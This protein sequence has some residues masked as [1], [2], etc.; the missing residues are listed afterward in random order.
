MSCDYWRKKYWRRLGESLKLYGDGP[1]TS[2][3]GLPSWV[4]NIVE[5][6]VE[7]VVKD[8]IENI[9]EDELEDVPIPES[10]RRT[11]QRT[12]TSNPFEYSLE[13]T[14]RRAKH[15]SRTQ[16]K[17]WTQDE[18]NSVA[19]KTRKLLRRIRLLGLPENASLVHGKEGLPRI[20]SQAGYAAVHDLLV[21]MGCNLD[22]VFDLVY[23]AAE[24]SKDL[25]SEERREIIC[26]IERIEGQVYK[27]S[28]ADISSIVK[29][30]QRIQ[31][32]SSEIFDLLMQVFQ[33]LSSKRRT[34]LE[35][36]NL[37]KKVLAGVTSFEQA[38]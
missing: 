29:D 7:D 18:R 9:L 27:G 36:R 19:K 3:G 24:N 28:E 2:N 32:I 8:I 23:D 10:T 35:M 25:R 26:L 14:Y 37:A 5:D 20:S 1:G 34:P 15:S 4:K 13:V 30:I 22:S 17:Q 11:L 33:R 6:V 16:Q 38:G 12:R 21:E 31:A